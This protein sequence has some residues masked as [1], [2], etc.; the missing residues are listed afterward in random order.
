MLINEVIIKESYAEE[1]IVAVQDLL[2]RVMAKDIKEISTDKFRR[3]LAKNGHVISID[4]L[5]QAVSRSG[6]ASSVDS[7]TIVPTSELPADID[8]DAEPTVDVGDL[9]GTQAMSDIKADL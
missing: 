7:E 6:F 4:E 1:I 3:I 5:I 2:S 9:A 8:T